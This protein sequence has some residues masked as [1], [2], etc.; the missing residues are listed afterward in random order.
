MR[1]C[2][3]PHAY[4][5]HST[6]GPL[7]PPARVGPISVPVTSSAAY[8]SAYCLFTFFQVHKY[9]PETYFERSNLIQVETLIEE[10]RHL[11]RNL[12]VTVPEESVPLGEGDESDPPVLGV[13]LPPNVTRLLEAIEHAGECGLA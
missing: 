1:D 13:M 7:A 5:I 4:V 10:L 12:I 9:S 6:A 3:D 8:V 11:P 2:K